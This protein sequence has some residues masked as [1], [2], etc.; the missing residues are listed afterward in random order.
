[1]TKLLEKAFAEASK[2]PQ[3]EQDELGEWIL[4]ELASERR[5][6]DAFARSQDALERM[7]EKALAEYHAG[8]TKELNPDDL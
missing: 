6:D 8:K 7:A 2:L 3:E 5:W 1:M 4:D